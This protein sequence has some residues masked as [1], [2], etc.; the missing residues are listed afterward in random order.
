MS[1]LCTVY[2]HEGRAE[3]ELWEGEPPLWLS[4][5]AAI[6]SHLHQA[7]TAVET[8]LLGVMFISKSISIGTSE[9][10]LDVIELVRCRV[11]LFVS[12]CKVFLKRVAWE[13]EA[14]QL[15]LELSWNSQSGQRCDCFTD[16]LCVDC[17]TSSRYRVIPRRF[18]WEH[19]QLV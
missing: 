18:V 11:G 5:A 8:P 12:K 19:M 14:A 9:L 13:T 17:W 7:T 16:S 1:I 10:S 4:E 3:W 2:A 6:R 15:Q